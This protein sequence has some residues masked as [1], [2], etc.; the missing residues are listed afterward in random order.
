MNE[1]SIMIEGEGYGMKEIY[2][3]MIEN[4]EE[5]EEEKEKEAIEWEDEGETE[6]REENKEVDLAGI[7]DE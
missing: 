2:D 4:G 6:E 3:M 7:E 1:N 5:E